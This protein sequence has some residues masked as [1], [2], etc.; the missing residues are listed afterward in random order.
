MSCA[1]LA[2]HKFARV[3]NAKAVTQKA[4]DVFLPI[5]YRSLNLTPSLSLPHS[6]FLTL[7]L[8]LTLTPSLTPT[9]TFSITHTI[10]D[11]HSI[12]HTLTAVA[13]SLTSMVLIE[14]RCLLMHIDGDW[15]ILVVLNAIS[16]DD[17]SSD[18]GNSMTKWYW[19][20]GV[21]LVYCAEVIKL[22]PFLS[23]FL[24]QVSNMRTAI[25]YMYVLLLLLL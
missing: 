5:S 16:A 18:S 12:T 13:W 2:G 21:H 17:I 15:H 3:E 11:T 22:T 6:H 4:S 7:A 10:T 19:S 20:A 1:W 8:T 9:L 14:L 24:V 23:H 25:L